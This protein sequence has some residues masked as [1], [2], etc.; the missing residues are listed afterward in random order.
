[1]AEDQGTVDTAIDTIAKEAGALSIEIVDVAG[2]VDEVAGRIARQAGEFH[3]LAEAAEQVAESNATIVAAAERTRD[4]AARAAGDVDASRGTVSDAVGEI[5]ALVDGVTAIE[6]RLGGLQEALSRVGKIAGVINA[7]AKQTNLL[8]LNATIEAARAGEAG[9]GFAV[10]AG[11]VKSLANQTADATLDIERTLKDLE[12]QARDLMDQG[13]HTTR[14]ADGVR[15]GTEAIGTAMDTIGDAVSDIASQAETIATDASRIAESS[16]GFRATI[17]TLSDEVDRSSDTLQEARDRVN[18]LIDTGE[19]LAGYCA[20]SGANSIDRPFIDKVR[21]VAGAVSDAFEAA[22]ARGDIALDALFDRQYAAIPGTDPQQLRA[23][24]LAVTDRLLPAIQEPA[25][26]F[27][28]RI[29]FCAAVDENGYLPTHNNKFSQPQGKDPVWN[30]ANC[31]NRRLFNDRVGLKA[32][33]NREPF[34]LQ[35]YRRDMGGGVFALMKDVSAPITVRGRHWGGV[36]LAY[37]P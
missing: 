33:R 17:T 13:T 10:V 32:G 2:N 34:L 5:Q 36:R 16:A 30:A 31:R 37:K 7:I 8:A 6:S 24:C 20:S 29:V 3:R 12:A 19:R 22:V 26:A 25:L 11:E 21:E 4:I 9:R 15:G 35:T 27:D 1:M 28:P 14:L 23:G 18:R